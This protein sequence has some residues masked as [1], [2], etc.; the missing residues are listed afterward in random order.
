MEEKIIR[1]QKCTFCK[2]TGKQQPSGW[3]CDVCGG[4]GKMPI[5]EEPAS[6][7]TPTDTPAD[8]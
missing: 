7:E 8:K 1:R 3:K 2:G 5:Y 4:T 6:E